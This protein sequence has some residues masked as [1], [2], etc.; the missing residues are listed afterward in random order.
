MARKRYS[1]LSAAS[2]RRA[3][4]DRLHVRQYR[5]QQKFS[6][7]VEDSVLRGWS[8]VT[9][10]LLAGVQND[11]SIARSAADEGLRIGRQQKDLELTAWASAVAFITSLDVHVDVQTDAKNS[12]TARR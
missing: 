10:A 2:R 3:A 4:S 9:T 1:N 7:S 5:R 12:S 6:V 8:V 11:P